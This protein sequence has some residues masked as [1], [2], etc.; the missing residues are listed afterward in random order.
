MKTLADFKRNICV[1][2]KIQCNSIEEAPMIENKTGDSANFQFGDLLIVPMKEKLQGERI[3][4]KKDTTGFYLSHN[5]L[6]KGSFCKYPKSSALLYDGTVFTITEYT[7]DG[8]VWQRRHYS[9]IA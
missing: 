9:I 4:T 7:K 3:V 2:V 8:Q 5:P 1:G 6:T